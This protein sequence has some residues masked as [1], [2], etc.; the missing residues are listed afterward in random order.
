MLLFLLFLFPERARSAPRQ[1]T[2][3]QNGLRQGGPENMILAL[4]NL[5]YSLSVHVLQMVARTRYWYSQYLYCRWLLER[6]TG[7]VSTCTVDGCKNEALV[8]LVPVLQMVART[9]YWYSQYL[10]CRWLLERGT[11]IVSTYTVDGC[12]NEVLVQLVP[13]LQMVAKTRY[14]YSQYLYCRWLLRQG[15]GIVSTCTVD[16]C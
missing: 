1:R 3:V 4:C 11:G 2:L 8:Q 14:W 7:I 12:Q 15:N 13:V 16:G 9:R 10:Y 5:Y 6:D